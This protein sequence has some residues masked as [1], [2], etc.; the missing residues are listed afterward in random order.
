MCGV[1]RRLFNVLAAVSLVLCVAAGALWV[2]TGFRAIGWEYVNTNVNGRYVTREL[3]SKHGGIDYCYYWM[4]ATGASATQNEF[5][6][7]PT[8]P[9]RHP[10]LCSATS[11]SFAL[12][13]FY[14]SRRAWPST[15]GMV[16]E[17]A[18]PYWAIMLA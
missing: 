12:V 10:L 3:F 18:V 7:V 16:Y 14:V 5:A 4:R 13:G 6:S 17:I 15:I 1:K 11:T 9:S 8:T 2:S